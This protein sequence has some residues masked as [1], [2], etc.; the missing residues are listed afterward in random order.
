MGFKDPVYTKLCTLKFIIISAEVQNDKNCDKSKEKRTKIHR[1]TQRELKC[2]HNPV[3]SVA[4]SMSI[5]ERASLPS[6]A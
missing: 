1:S 5:T 2:S 3:K 4:R 6:K